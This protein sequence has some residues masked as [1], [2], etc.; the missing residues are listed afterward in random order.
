M[1]SGNVYPRFSPIIIY[2]AGD[3]QSQSIRDRNREKRTSAFTP[4]NL[5]NMTALYPPGTSY[6]L[7]CSTTAAMPSGTTK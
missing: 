4:V 1:G 6:R 3:G 7:F 5:S 2:N